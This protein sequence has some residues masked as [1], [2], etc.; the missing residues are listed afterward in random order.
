MKVVRI[1]FVVA[2]LALLVWGLLGES[3]AVHSLL[4]PPREMSGFEFSKAAAR[5][6]LTLQGSV[7]YELYRIDSPQE[8]FCAT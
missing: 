8:D 3:H 4:S 5:D 2:C 1:A 7:L 6:G